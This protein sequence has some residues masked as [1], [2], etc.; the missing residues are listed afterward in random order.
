MVVSAALLL[1]AGLAGAV[2][3]TAPPGG[4]L[5]RAATWALTASSVL[6]AATAVTLIVREGRV[7][8]AAALLAGCPAVAVVV[9]TLQARRLSRRLAAA[10][11]MMREIRR[12]HRA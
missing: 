7:P 6:T 12:S 5:C 1:G 3:L 11:A 10:Q 2:A 8:A 4:R 9:A